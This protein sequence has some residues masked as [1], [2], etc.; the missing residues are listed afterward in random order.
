M[1]ALLELSLGFLSPV[2]PSV[3][4]S[5]IFPT[6]PME[7]VTFLLHSCALHCQIIP[8]LDL[9]CDCLLLA[10][11]QTLCLQQ[12]VQLVTLLSPFRHAL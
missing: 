3:A 9:A 6:C 4:A 10:P 12:T 7:R 8:I 2:C 1:F 11:V 5:L